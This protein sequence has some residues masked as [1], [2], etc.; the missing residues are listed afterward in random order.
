MKLVIMTRPSFFVEENKIIEALFEEGMNNLHLYKPNTS[1]VYSERL[2]SLLP[3]EYHKKISIH[4]HFYLKE[5]FTL[6]GIHLDD[7]NEEPPAGYKGQMS[8]TCNDLMKLKRMKKTAKYVFLRDVFGSRD[9]RDG[10]SGY[11]PTQLL[12]AAHARLFD[13]HVYAMGGVNRDNI[14]IADDLGFEGVVICND[15]WSRFNIHHQQ[16]FRELI[17]YFRELKKLVD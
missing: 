9:S 13:R 2:L 6:A 16:D 15:L 17:S 7:P 11:T 10:S 1:P 8:R 5:Q 14:R 4:Q 3:E 12:Q